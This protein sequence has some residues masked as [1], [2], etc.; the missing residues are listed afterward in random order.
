[1]FYPMVICLIYK[2]ATCFVFLFIVMEVGSSRIEKKSLDTKAVEKVASHV[3][4]H[5][6]G[7]FTGMRW[8][9][10]RTWHPLLSEMAWKTH[11][12]IVVKLEQNRRW[13][14]CLVNAYTNLHGGAYMV[15]F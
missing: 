15:E 5:D 1:M 11:E 6:W 13:C 7:I 2:L 14:T 9:K 12:Y 4:D 3:G 8:I 10:R